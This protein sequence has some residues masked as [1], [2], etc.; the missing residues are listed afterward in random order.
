MP[1][2]KH[3]SLVILVLYLILSIHHISASNPLPSPASIINQQP[4]SP[5]LL[6]IENKN[7][8]SS[9]VIFKSKL[10]PGYID[11]ERDKF[12]FVFFNQD[13]HELHAHHHTE[14]SLLTGHVFN[15]S[16]VNANPNV[17]FDRHDANPTYLNYFI[18]DDQSKWASHVNQF[19][20]IT[21]RNLYAEST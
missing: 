14:D 5:D 21:Y 7:Q 13:L 10:V 2:T 19:K 16:F 11:F 1:K 3:H 15:L 4:T 17:S 9:A 6:F 12:H 18:G 20:S 8:W